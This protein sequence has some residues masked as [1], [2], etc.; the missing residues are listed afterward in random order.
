VEL[1]SLQVV[2]FDV[3]N[4]L[5]DEDNALN[6]EEQMSFGGLDGTFDTRLLGAATRVRKHK[7]VL[8]LEFAWDND[9]DLDDGL[10]KL[11]YGIVE[12][13]VVGLLDFAVVLL[14]NLLWGDLDSHGLLVFLF[15]LHDKVRVVGVTLSQGLFQ[16]N[17][18]V[19]VNLLLIETGGY[20][21]SGLGSRKALEMFLY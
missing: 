6:E 18:K 2:D 12:E 7:W 14:G 9:V 21:S 16:T 10:E 19:C 5:G 13:A 8:P 15:E 3:D 20:T 11:G 1:D 4:G 17:N